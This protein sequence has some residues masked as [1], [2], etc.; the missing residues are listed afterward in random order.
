M[1]HK[2]SWTQES[3]DKL[4]Y[5]I[6]DHESEIF[7]NSLYQCITN[8]CDTNIIAEKFDDF[9]SQACEMVFIFSSCSRQSNKD[10]PP[11][12]DN[13]WQ[14]KR[15]FGNNTLGNPF[16]YPGIN[17][18][19]SFCYFRGN[20]HSD[21]FNQ[22][23]CTGERFQSDLDIFQF[24]F[25]FVKPHN[26]P[27][28]LCFSVQTELRFGIEQLLL[29]VRFKFVFVQWGW[30]WNIQRNHSWYLVGRRFHPI[31]RKPHWSSKDSYMAC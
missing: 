13:E 3:L 31:F 15:S 12:Y 19:H 30:H 18:T 4:I 2:Y 27:P 11:W 17:I 14:C 9:I 21:W 16:A 10:V 22:Y 28:L 29:H 23:L 26:L 1:C 25:M 6:S 24:D 20:V 7:L 5:V 8:L